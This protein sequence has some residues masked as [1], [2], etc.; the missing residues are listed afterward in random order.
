[1]NTKT[2]EQNRL[3]Q[4][5]DFRYQNTLK[6]L[7]RVLTIRFYVIWDVQNGYAI[8]SRVSELNPGRA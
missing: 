4:N 3:K 8:H 6:A 7:Y 2:P 1:M 5:K